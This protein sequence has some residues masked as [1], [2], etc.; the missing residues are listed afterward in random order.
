MNR[1][2]GRA[3]RA[4][5]ILLLAGL[6]CLPAWARS[7]H[8]GPAAATVPANLGD[9]APRRH[10]SPA[11][12]AGTASPLATSAAG[13]YVTGT[14]TLIP[15]PLGREALGP[16]ATPL[17]GATDIDLPGGG[18]LSHRGSRRNRPAGARCA[19]ARVP[20]ATANATSCCALV[21]T[22]IAATRCSTTAAT[23]CSGSARS[24]RVAS[25][26]RGTAKPDLPSP[27]ATSAQRG[28]S[29]FTTGARGRTGLSSPLSEQGVTG[30]RGRDSCPRHRHSES[31]S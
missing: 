29:A 1:P 27:G 18:R 8:A 3:M 11:R 21:P 2:F 26:E 7:E 20:T 19:G 22:P 24:A 5:P 17:Q 25:R 12:A 10:T 6:S 15:S 16:A 14:L 9:P 30:C 4:G 28:N 13:T 31:N 23:P